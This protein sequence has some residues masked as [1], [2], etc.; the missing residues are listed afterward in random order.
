MKRALP[1]WANLLIVAAYLTTT[2]RA[3][4]VADT[5]RFCVSPAPFVSD[6]PGTRF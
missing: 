4:E 2:T 3:G 1:G 6:T 5:S